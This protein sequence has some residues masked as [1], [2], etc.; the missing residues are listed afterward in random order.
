MVTNNIFR[1][2]QV[3]G[4]SMNVIYSQ[5]FFSEYPR[6]VVVNNGYVALITQKFGSPY[7]LTKIYLY[8][9]TGIVSFLRYYEKEGYL[10]SAREQNGNL[11][12]IVQYYTITDFTWDSST[13]SSVSWATTC[14]S[15]NG[16][17]NYVR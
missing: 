3:N 12:I 14:S 16:L 17:N 1:V 2:V 8:Q 9:N 7:P 4:L 13:G 11:N 6:E 15:W 10:V 5:N